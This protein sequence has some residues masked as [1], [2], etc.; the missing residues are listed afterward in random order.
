MYTVARHTL[1]FLITDMVAQCLPVQGP[2]AICCESPG[3]ISEQ[4]E[5]LGANKLGVLLTLSVKTAPRS[6]SSGPSTQEL[7]RG[8]KRV[9]PAPQA[10]GSG[11]AVSL[12]GNSGG[13]PWSC[14]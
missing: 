12:E 2:V 6:S 9:P 7:W 3:G 13:L 5:G 11:L 8:K 10:E 14:Q 4:S 1:A